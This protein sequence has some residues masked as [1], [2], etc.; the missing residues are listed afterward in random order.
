MEKGMLQMHGTS[1]LRN[2][3]LPSFLILL[4]ESINNNSQSHCAM[5]ERHAKANSEYELSWRAVILSLVFTIQAVAPVVVADVDFDE[6]TICQ[7]SPSTLGGV[8]DDRMDAD[9]GTPDVTEWVEG[10]FHFNMS[11]PT[12]IQ[13]QASWAIREWSKG[14]LG[15]FS[16]QGMTTALQSD[17]IM[18]NDGLPADVLR[19][20]FDENTD[21]NDASSPTVQESLMSEIDGSISTFLSNWGGSSTPETSWRDSIYLPD[22][23]GEMEEVGCELDPLMDSN[24]NAFEPPICISTNVTITLDVLGTYG[25]AVSPSDLNTALEGLLIMG[26]EITTNFDVRVQPGHKGV[27]AIQPPSYA[28]VADAGGWVGEEISEDNGAYHSALWS[29]DN[30]DAPTGVLQAD[31]DMSMAY[32]EKE[33]TQ[34]VEVSPLSKSLDLD[35]T[36]DLSDESASFIE[37]IVGIYQIQASTLSNW[38]VPALMPANKA[39]VPV[40]TSDGIR[41]AYH[42]GLLDLTDL[43]NNI[44]VSGIGEALGSSDGG[45]GVT[46]GGFTWMHISQAPLDQGGL[47]YTHGPP[48]TRGQHF[49]MEGSVAMDDT[50]PVYMRSISHTFPLSLADL[51]GG[52]LGDS[53]FMNSVSG[54][55][56]GKLLNS[57]MEFS[58]TLS[59]DVMEDFVGSLLPNGVNADLT[60]S[61]VLPDW[62]STLEGGDT[63]Q[64]SYRSSGD[65]DS[66]ISLT[67]SEAFSWDHAICRKTASEG[68]F[69]STPD[70]VCPSTSRSCGYIDVNWD[71]QEVSFGSLPLTKGGSVQFALSVDLVIHRIGVPDILFDS[72]STESTTFDLDTL[73]ADLFRALLEI[74]SRGDP[75]EV[76]FSLCDEGMS[77]CEQT[78]P[79]SSSNTTGLPAYAE[80]LE[81]DIASLIE[82]STRKLTEDPNNDFGK[83]DMSELHVDIGFPHDMITDDDEVIGDERGIIL[84]LDIPDV[85]VTTGVDNSWFELI[86][87]LQ[88]GSGSPKIG[89][90]TTDPNGALLSPFLG[91]MFSAMNGL[92]GALSAS[93]V[94]ADGIRSAENI[95]LNFPT[96]GLSNIGEEGALAGAGLDL[97]GFINFSLPLEITLEDY[98]STQGLLTAVIDED[99]K[100]QTVSYEISPSIIDD[101][102]EF[103]VLIS[104]MWI[105]QQI[106]YYI[107]GLI[108]FI[109][110]RVRRRMTR[111]AR[112]RRA[113]A[114]I[115]LE[116]SLA[117]PVGYVPP[118]P[119]VE[120]LQVSDNGIVVK[121]RLVAT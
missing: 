65:H 18:E 75:L 45:T 37:I 26:S 80:K 33:G 7:D 15:L 4:T 38:G 14:G 73:P 83:I 120:V 104:P 8:C 20:S 87:M 3:G 70:V 121:R 56:F 112:K 22:D 9:D 10:I 93:M 48:C 12:E 68:C 108:G 28:T 94:S 76:E 109:L 40:I 103:N 82:Y 49:C 53:G 90:E 118:Q 69:D 105:L 35:V 44:P 67:G 39:N 85:R 59:D 72:I 81:R 97:T 86:K 110:W 58:T 100:R 6:M 91:P 29:V 27:Y 30:R 25:L 95:I 92:T 2:S 96:S 66:E 34:V 31:L 52:N 21:P 51:L 11:S 32:R 19:S 54:D 64:L 89:I 78:I 119:T 43:S 114:L 77:F 17:N 116:E 107:I 99:T 74:G 62:A 42:T 106:Q 13:F 113:E 84:S 101:K 61:I 41:M 98:S 57:G 47:N 16:S 5:A 46:M 1:R 117:S 55:D 71:L 115:A 111:K 50:Y 102:V 88:D 23:S 24:G 60:M 63:I 79:F 36:V